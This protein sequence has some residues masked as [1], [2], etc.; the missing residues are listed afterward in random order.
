MIHGKRVVVVMPAY[1]AERTL[2]R[3]IQEIPRDVVDEVLLVDDA[4]RDR[5]VELSVGLGLPT[6]VHHKNLGYGGNQKTCYAE[7]LERG[8]DV[9]V[10]LHPDYQYDPRLVSAMA[11]MIASDVFD[12][13]LGSRILGGGARS[14]GMPFYKYVSNRVLTLVQNLLIG[15]KV[16]EYH[17][18]YRAFSREVL[19][20]LP[21]EGNSDD[22]I[23]DNQMLAQAFYFGFRVGEISCPARYE[24]DS[25]S[26]N[27]ARSCRYGLGVLWT[28]VLYRLAKL[29]LVRPQ[30]FDPLAPRLN[31]D[32]LHE[33]ATR[34]L[35]AVGE[36]RSGPAG[37]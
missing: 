24:P 6:L 14:G 34:G 27:F 2:E 33:H 10:M 20:R 26:I 1:N 22:F 5:T 7:A 37:S 29:G 35:P 9:V 13:V 11:T 18:G 32:R 28:S 17:T 23:F 3:T 19:Q 21:L 31:L 30:T 15:Q 12:A 8:A 16:S 36:N 25:S 4:S